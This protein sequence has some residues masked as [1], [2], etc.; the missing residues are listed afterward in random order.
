[1]VTVSDLKLLTLEDELIL[2]ELTH[3]SREFLLSH[4]DFKITSKQEKEFEK[5]QRELKKGLPL[6]YVLGFKWFYTHKFEVNKDTLIPRPETELL[7]DLA[8]KSARKLKPQ[9]IVDIGTGSGAIIVSLRNAVKNKSDYHAS[10][11]SKGALKIAKRN[12]QSILQRNDITF[13]QGSLL[14]PHLSTLQK[15]NSLLVLSNLPYLAPSQMS[16]PSIKYEPKGALL[17]GKKGHELI[18]KLLQEIS[19]LKAKRITIL[20][21]FNYDQGKLIKEE[22]LKLFPKSKVGVYK[23]LNGHDRIIEISY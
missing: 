14:K 18:L 6:A 7:V 10:D 1:M 8:I 15:Y 4:P 2:S 20:L 17:G 12:A 9:A 5:K 3:K 16:E 21:E 13:K 22:A 11:I 19:T 23:D